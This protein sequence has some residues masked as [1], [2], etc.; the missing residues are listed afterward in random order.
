M[1]VEAGIFGSVDANAGD[2][3]LGWDVDRVP[4]SAEQMTLGMVEISGW[5]IRDTHDLTHNS[6]NW[7]E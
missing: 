3:R 2:D 7:P 6:P 1:A 5:L 4:V